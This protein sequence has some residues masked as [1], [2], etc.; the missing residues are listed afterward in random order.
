MEMEQRNR[1]A[2]PRLC[3]ALFLAGDGTNLKEQLLCRSIYYW[4]LKPIRQSNTLE[5]TRIIEDITS[6]SGKLYEAAREM[7]DSV[8][9][10]KIDK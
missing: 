2:Y 9:P 1:K 3:R 5:F 7:V 6:S 10:N 4:W 8:V